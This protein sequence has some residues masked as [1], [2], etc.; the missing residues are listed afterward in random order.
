[1]TTIEEYF[2]AW[3]ELYGSQFEKKLDFEVT[4]KEIARYAWKAG[5]R[6]SAGLKVL[7]VPPGECDAPSVPE[8]EGK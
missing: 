3:W 6:T 2:D 4:K 1:M 7:K 8:W 5:W